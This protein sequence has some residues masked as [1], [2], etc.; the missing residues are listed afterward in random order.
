MIACA[1]VIM[2]HASYASCRARNAELAELADAIAHVAIAAAVRGAE[3]LDRTR[4]LRF[5][6]REAGWRLT[7]VARSGRDPHAVQQLVALEARRGSHRRVDHHSQRFFRML[8][9]LM[10]LKTGFEFAAPGVRPAR[11]G[12]EADRL[13]APLDGDRQGL[14]FVK[15]GRMREAHTAR[16]DV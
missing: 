5:G 16:R 4:R 15:Q 9:D 8:I 10:N 2:A 7:R 11:L 6:N 1:P 3:E 13:P 14:S 12:D